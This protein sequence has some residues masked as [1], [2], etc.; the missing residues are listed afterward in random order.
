MAERPLSSSVESV[1]SDKSPRLEEL[2]LNKLPISSQ[3][4]SA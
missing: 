2:Q 4:I 1:K 3:K